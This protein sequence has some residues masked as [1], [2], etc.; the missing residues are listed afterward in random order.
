MKIGT[1]DINNIGIFIQVK[2]TKYLVYPVMNYFPEYGEYSLIA[3]QGYELCSWTK[4]KEY[5]EY[6]KL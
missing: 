2:A 4:S 5:P 6:D 3:I 1:K